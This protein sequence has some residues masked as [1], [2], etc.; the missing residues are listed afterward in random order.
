MTPLRSKFATAA[1]SYLFLCLLLFGSLVG[2]GSTLAPAQVVGDLTPNLSAASHLTKTSLPKAPPQVELPPPPPMRYV[3]GLEEPLVATG[4]TTHQQDADLDAALAAYHAAPQRLGPQADFA[5]YAKPLVAFIAAH[6]TSNWNAALYL[7]I[8]LGYFHAAYYSRTFEYFENAWQLGRNATTPQ[9]TLMADRAVGELAEMHARLGHAKELEALFADLGDR[10]IGGPA[11][12]MLQSAREGLGAFHYRP[13]IS[14]LC[15]PAALRAILVSLRASPQQVRIAND[16]R[17]GVHGFSLQQLAQLA[18]DAGLKF[19]LV[20]RK[21]GQPIPVPSIIN[22]KVHHYAA[23]VDSHDGL[24]QL[25][26]ATFGRRVGSVATIK[27]IDAE[28]SGYFL[29]P[30]TVHATEF[31]K[32]LRMVDAHSAEAKVVYGMG[33]VDDLAGGMVRHDDVGTCPQSGSAMTVACA[34][35]MA[36]SLTLTDRPVGYEPQKGPAVY[37][38][39]TY[40][41]RDG[42]Q[43]AN[44]TF[45]NV[46]LQ[47]NH[48]WQ[49]YIQDDPNNPGSDVTRIASGGGGY[50]YSIV[51]DGQIYN[52]GTGAFIP[53]TYDNSQLFRYPPTGQA[54]SYV[55]YLPNGGQEVYAQF[56]NATT[57]PRHVFLTQVIDPA[58]N[59]VT[60]TYGTQGNAVILNSITDAMGR[61]T[62]FQYNQTLYPLLITNIIDP[63]GRSSQL[64]YDGYGRL[65]SITDPIGITSGF[66]Y[67]E[68]AEPY[69]VTRLATPYGASKFSDI[70]NQNDPQTGCCLDLS[71]AMTDPL[72]YV[73]FLYFYQN[74]AITGTPSS[75]NQAPTGMSLD[76]GHLQWRNTYYWDRHVAAGGNVTTDSNGNPIA[77]NW[78]LPTLPA[79]TNL[80]TIYHWMQMC[81]YGS[82]YVNNQIG[83]IKKPLEE[84]RQ[85]Y[86]YPNC[87]QGEGA[88]Y[89]SGTLMKPTF[90]GRVLDDG[91]T[92]LTQETYN[93]FGLPL[94]YIDP[95]GRFTKFTY[96]S[97]NIDLLTVQQ[98]TAS[99]LATVGIFSNYNNQHEPQT[100][101]GADGNVWRYS[102]NAAGQLTT[103]TDPNAGVTTYNYDPIGRLSTVQNANR[104]TVLTFTYD[105][106]DRV[107]TRTDSQGYRLTYTY[108]NLDRVTQIT[109]PDGSTDL[110][111]WTFQSGEYQGTPSLELRKYT[112]RLG[113]VTTYGYDAD[114][115]LTSV[116]E[117]ISSGVN[118]TTSFDY[119]ENGVLK[120]I[121]DAKS[122][123]T[124]WDVDLESRPMSKTYA[125]GTTNQ[126]T[127]TLAYEAT[128]S[129]LKSLTDALAE[130]KRYTYGLDDRLTGITY[131]NAANPT[132]NVTFGYDAYFPRLTSMTDGTGTSNYTYTPI[133]TNGA[134]QLASEE[135][136]FNNDSIGYT[137]DVLGR[138]STRTIPGGNEGFTYDAISRLTSHSTGLGTFNYVYLGE[139]SQTTLQSVTN[140]TI[141]ISTGWSYDTNNND[142]RLIHIINSGTTRSYS[143]NYRIPGGGGTKDPYDIQG[144]AAIPASPAYPF[145][146]LTYAYSYDLSDRLLL[147]TAS[148]P[149]SPYNHEYVYNV[150][151]DATTVIDGQNQTHASYNSLNEIRSWGGNN[152]FYDLNGNTQSGD[153]TRSYKWDA[154]NRLVEIDYV[155][156]NAKTQFAY[157][158]LGRRTVGIETASGGGTTTDRYLWC[159]DGRVC[160][161]R[162]G[163][164]DVIRRVMWEGE[165]NV[166]TGKKLIYMPDQLGSAG[167]VLDGTTG[168][169]VAA[170]EFSPYGSIA[171]TYGTAS[172]NYR[173]AGL[174]YHPA[175]ALNFAKYRQ[176]DGVTGRFLNRDP[177][178]QRGG[179]NNLYDYVGANAVNANDPLGLC[180]VQVLYGQATV[181]G[182]SVGYHS[183][184]LVTATDGSADLPTY[185]QALPKNGA[186]PSIGFLGDV[187]TTPIFF[188]DWGPLVA[189][190]GPY[191]AHAALNGEPSDIWN[192]KPPFPQTILDNSGSCDFVCAKLENYV[193]AVNNNN[194]PYDP[195]FKN[196][197]AFIRGAI[198]A[199]GLPVPNPPVSLYG[200]TTNL[201]VH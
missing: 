199:A 128:T 40:N 132:P 7:N 161:T 113:R 73:D 91:S 125:Y 178:K 49:A 65:S 1:W 74:Q 38:T 162:D 121:T 100:Y 42:D 137:Y 166:T 154:E 105:S 30:T 163:G 111:D 62:T 52:S 15:G 28:S 153:G 184:L 143:L 98:N 41:A 33:Q 123:V 72:G 78:T 133:G 19:K 190:Y 186:I 144:L 122:N 55:R 158:G 182:H 70:P 148:S 23:I 13:E 69:F 110:Y 147:A 181:D 142:R 131:T 68:R 56:D 170:Y 174:F 76:Q 17:S 127:E 34:R 80:P 36:V 201:G 183:Y 108:D 151:D 83:S 11:V 177:M 27:A 196:S 86:N 24:Y 156:S 64:N 102:Y 168:S 88:P 107:L 152:Y 81:C 12:Q 14:Y 115:R 189:S 46:S 109:Y 94:T 21:P 187:G 104:Q 43:P 140:G 185:F 164:D 32:G 95:T 126:E 4:A 5:D 192:P 50:D 79:G 117:P 138:L 101:T 93:N 71:L 60:L 197:N 92:Q 45:S 25:R 77:E 39:L 26:D 63:F 58:G 169:L 44:F 194:I 135:G 53:E 112:D 90:I 18:D 175:S 172:I 118:R 75:E 198:Q 89:Y 29:V 195:I 16:A 67:Q 145:P 3:P 157:D 191:G 87:C 66:R 9:A 160:Q 141:N 130:V 155:G 47:W 22:W 37:E 31:S 149:G 82:G 129:R 85:W 99:G 106:A 2:A 136:P 171:D 48:S 103:I 54:T 188:P 35:M 179:I 150:V 173:Y 59:S 57:Y 96:A 167:D 84:Y 159:E 97:N 20:Y 6:P 193:N 139:T 61:S 51:E 120:D 146:S 165:L 8:G 10:P 200:W 116:T 119:Y 176:L 134:L 124:H 114:R 180:K